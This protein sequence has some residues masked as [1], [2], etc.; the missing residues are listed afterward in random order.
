MKIVVV[1][2][3]NYKSFY[4]NCFV[5]LRA[6]DLLIFNYGIIYDYVVETEILHNAVV[7]NELMMLSHKLKCPVVA[8]VYVVSKERKQSIIVCDG[9]KIH[10]FDAHQG[11][12]VYTKYKT[13]C[14]G[15]EGI[16]LC[17]HNKIVL[18]DKRLYPSSEHCS[19]NKVYLFCDRF[20]VSL[21]ENKTFKRFFSKYAQ[22]IL[23]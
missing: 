7:T 5:K 3:G 12:T 23:K 9:E 16:S 1:T 20:G 18:G 8:G 13:F 21:V 17:K 4:L 6:C 19:K 15:V 10:I 11:A 22:I 2:G 14:I